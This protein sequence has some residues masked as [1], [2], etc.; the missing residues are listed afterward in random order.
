[1]PVTT[2]TRKALALLAYLAVT[3]RAHTRDTLAALLWGDADEQHAR[4]ALRRTLFAIRAAAGDDAVEIAGDMLGAGRGVWCDVVAFRTAAKAG[5]VEAAALAVAPFM[6]GFNL[7]DAPDFEE[8]QFLEA[9]ALSRELA[10]VLTRLATGL[11]A[12]GDYAAAAVHARRLRALDPLNEEAHRLL[13][14]L[15]AYGGDQAAALRQYRE[16]VRILDQDLGVGPLPETTELY[17]AIRENRVT[18]P[19]ARVETPHRPV[20]GVPDE[21]PRSAASAGRTGA[22]VVDAGRSLRARG[23]E[24]LLRGPGRRG[25]HRQ[26]AAG[27]GVRGLRPGARR[28]RGGRALF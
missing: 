19:V 2:D 24:R 11:I 7:R 9:E 17:Q 27:R 12:G 18:P 23:A 13:M 22:G 5:L 3:Q 6:P 4:G 26:D 14:R 8:W 10:E 20:A 1:M 21:R 25:R 16:C 15:Y 28:Q